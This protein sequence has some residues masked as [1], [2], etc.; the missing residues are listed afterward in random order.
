M[1]LYGLNELIK[2]N[3]RFVLEHVIKKKPLKKKEFREVIN[4]VLG[5]PE[6]VEKIYNTVDSVTENVTVDKIK[7]LKCKT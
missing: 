5:D 4:Y 7:C 3:N 6:K 1:K 2:D